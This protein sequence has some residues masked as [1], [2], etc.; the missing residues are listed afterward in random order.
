MVSTSF[1]GCPTLSPIGLVVVTGREVFSR[2]PCP[3]N[4]S[5]GDGFSLNNAVNPYF[6]VAAYQPS[7]IPQACTQGLL[8]D[9][10]RVVLLIDGEYFG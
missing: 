2:C 6:H 1:T 9:H 8:P 3:Q 7:K 10:F 5:A 4:L